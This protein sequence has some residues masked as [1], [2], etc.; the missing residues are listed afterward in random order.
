ML[1]ITLLVIKHVQGGALEWWD[2]GV[3]GMYG[4]C[5]GVNTRRWTLLGVPRPLKYLLS[6]LLSFSVPL[7]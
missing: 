7:D 5:Y 6:L 2:G 1:G 4:L 3:R